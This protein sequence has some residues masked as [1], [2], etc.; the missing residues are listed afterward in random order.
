MRLTGNVLPVPSAAIWEMPETLY[1]ESQGVTG[2]D[3][4]ETPA[5]QQW[6]PNT[7]C[8]EVAGQHGLNGPRY[9]HSTACASGLIDVLSAVR[10]IRDDQCDI[11]LAGSAEALSP[12]FAAGFNKLRVLAHNSDPSQACRPFDRDRNGFV[13]GEGAAMFCVGAD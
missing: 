13:M 11:A 1:L 5:W 2:Q 7:A 8:S 3:T 4:T 9:C 10:A 6:L 12:L